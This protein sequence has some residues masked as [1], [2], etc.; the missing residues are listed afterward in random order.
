MDKRKQDPLQRKIP[1]N[2]KYETISSVVKTGKTMRD[3]EIMSNQAVA[4]RRGELFRRIRPSTLTK[5]L[6]T[7]TN[8]ESIYEVG[9]DPEEMKDSDDVA[10]VFSMAASE[11]P[12]MFSVVTVNTEALGIGQDTEFILLDLREESEFKQFHIKEALCY[13]SPN[14]TRDRF[15]P[16]VHRLRNVPQ[17]YIVVYAW[18]ERPGVEA[19]QRF[20]EKGFD[21]VYLLSGGVEEFLAKCPDMVEGQPP[22]LA[23]PKTKRMA[24]TGLSRRNLRK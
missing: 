15:P 24:S 6:C 17:K 8:F 10:S 20:A 21:N 14:I 18:D 2:P 7:I 9:G 5:L 11:A 16:E 13:P 19:A 12:S 1:K 3:I 23:G 4:R 22:V